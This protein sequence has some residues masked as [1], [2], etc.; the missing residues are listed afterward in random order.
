MVS[1]VQQLDISDA[2]YLIDGGLGKVMPY[3]VR[4]VPVVIQFQT[5]TW[6][7]TFATDI[8]CLFSTV[9]LESSVMLS[10]DVD[11]AL[12]KEI[13]VDI[14]TTTNLNICKRH[15]MSI[16]D[17]IALSRTLPRTGDSFVYAKDWHI[18]RCSWAAQAYW[19]PLCLQ[20][21]WL[22][23]YW[24]RVRVKSEDDYSFAYVG[25]RSSVT[26]L[27][28]DVGCSYSWSLNIAGTKQWTLFAPQDAHC[29]FEVPARAAGTFDCNSTMAAD[30]RI[31][32]L[33]ENSRQFPL[34]ESAHRWECLQLP[35]QCMFVPSGWFHMVENVPTEGYSDR[36]EHTAVRN[37][38]EF[39]ISLNRNWWNAG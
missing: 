4:N 29:L 30:C 23:W 7:E 21:D 27:H 5:V 28:H 33:A 6:W 35:G 18:D 19:V 20:D 22:N 25:G 16:R 34:L 10:D 2:E 12:S 39:T 11:D 3:L 9:D 14:G 36:V 8:C 13:P 26:A 17:F 37:D 38:S 32:S 15:S 24:K 31:Q 1:L